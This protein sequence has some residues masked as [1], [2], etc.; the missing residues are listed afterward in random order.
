MSKKSNDLSPNNSNLQDTYAWVLYKMGKYESAKKWLEQSMQNGGNK[1]A[2]V[3]E[4]YGDALYKLNEKDKAF[5]FW[6][7][8]KET[9]KGSE[10]LERKI[11]EKQLIE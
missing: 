1:S 9:G 2:T 4:H 8:A 7:K 5:E 11:K 10:F 6:I 3:I